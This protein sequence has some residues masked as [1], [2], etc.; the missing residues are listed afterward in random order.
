MAKAKKQNDPIVPPDSAF[1]GT[2]LS[3]FQSFLCNTEEEHDRLSNTIELWDSIPKY[4]VTQQQMNKAR[5]KEGFLPRLEKTFVYKKDEYKVRISPAQIDDEEGGEKSYYPSANEEIIEDALRKIASEQN[6]GFFDAP[7]FKSGVVFSLNMLRNELKR[8]GHTRSYQE[9]I[10]S[11]NILAGSHIEILLP[12][13]KGFAKT[14]Y[15]PSLVAVSRLRWEEDPDARWMAHFHPLVT[16]SISKLSYRQ[17]DYHLMMSHT[18][19]LARWLHKILSHNY[20]NA[21]LINPY[22]TSLS[23]IKRDSGLLE[24]KRMNDEVRKL[25]NVLQELIEHRVLFSYN[26]TDKRGDR[27][28]IIDIDYVLAPHT[29]FVRDVKAA[30]KRQQI[31]KSPDTKTLIN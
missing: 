7:E 13:G 24:C 4:S 15:L 27:N 28:K 18:S 5:I 12:N 25:E 23:S 30:N 1:G 9:I 17:Y 31:S 8:R 26:K 21:S 16:Q 3:L 14:N 11:L 6:K 19:Q 22:N 20:L 10:R 2:Q 29:D